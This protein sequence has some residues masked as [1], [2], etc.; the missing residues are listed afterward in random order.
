MTLS[1]MITLEVIMQLASR[2]SRYGSGPGSPLV[3]G[4]SMTKTVALS[5]LSGD[6]GYFEGP[7]AQTAAV[8]EMAAKN[9]GDIQQVS[10]LGDKAHWAGSTPDRAIGP[11]VVARPPCWAS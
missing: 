6:A 2:Q 5:V 11:A 1:A 8:Y 7:V 9:A 3:A 10:G 4:R